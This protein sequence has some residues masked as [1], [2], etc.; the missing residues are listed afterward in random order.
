M[1]AQRTKKT[2][3]SKKKV[4]YFV[5]RGV[6]DHRVIKVVE[7]DDGSVQKES[8]YKVTKSGCEC[9]AFSF[10]RECKH[11]DMVMQERIEG[12]PVSLSE[13][14]KCVRH[15]IQEFRAVFG[16]VEL[17]PEPYERDEEDRIVCATI[18]LG[19]PVRESPI[20]TEGTWEGCLRENK[21]KVRLVIE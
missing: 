19:K 8:E 21:L 10:K 20:L 3:E 15:L 14:R 5:K 1:M 6:E 18:H 7:D 4:L 16:R 11:V 9:K 17:P 13:A 12:S 2:K